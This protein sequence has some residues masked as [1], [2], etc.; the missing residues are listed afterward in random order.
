MCYTVC[1]LFYDTHCI[2]ALFVLKIIVKYNYLL[3]WWLYDSG[4]I[5]TDKFS[6]AHICFDYQRY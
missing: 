6:G 1:V 3:F 2:S 4:T 5:R